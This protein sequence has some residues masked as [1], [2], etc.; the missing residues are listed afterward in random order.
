MRDR[1]P[2][3]LHPNRRQS[4]PLRYGHHGKSQTHILD[5]TSGHVVTKFIRATAEKQRYFATLRNRT[6]RRPRPI[7]AEFRFRPDL[8]LILYGLPLEARSCTM[9]PPTKLA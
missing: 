9:C 2:T 5:L 3:P 4:V 6:W 7:T 1:L 8:R